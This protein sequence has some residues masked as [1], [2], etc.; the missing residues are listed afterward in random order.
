MRNPQVKPQI[1]TQAERKDSLIN[2]RITKEEKE[3][4]SK[5]AEQSGLN[6]SEYMRQLAMRDAERVL[7]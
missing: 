3:Q 7:G 5:Q 2:L 4:V 1:K 6:V